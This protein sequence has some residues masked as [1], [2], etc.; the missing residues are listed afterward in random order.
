MSIS[1]FITRAQVPNR[2]FGNIRAG[3]PELGIYNTPQMQYSA[4]ND[5]EL[6]N[7]GAFIPQE[8]K[9]IFS[10]GE[11]LQN[12]SGGAV[13]FGKNL[14]GRYIASQ[15]LGTGG[16]MVFGL[17]GALAVLFLVG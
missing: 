11:L 13:D 3:Q 7:D 1:K 12:L 15:A 5:N 14:A 4:D 10:L 17:P 2:R 8:E 16:G 9:G 6:Q